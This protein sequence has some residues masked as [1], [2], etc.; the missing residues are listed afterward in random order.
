MGKMANLGKGFEEEVKVANKQYFNKRVAIIQQI[1]TPWKVIR[2]GKKIVHAFPEGK[3]TLDFRGTVKGGL[4]ISFDCKE[5]KVEKGLPLSNIAEHQISYMR[6]AIEFGE[7]SFVLCNITS[8]N[9]RYFVDGKTVIKKW[10]EW[11]ENKGKR[12]YNFIPVLDMIEIK[13]RNGIVLDY[14]APIRG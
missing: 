4:S 9:K 1:P 10:D 8:I 12:G 5:T 2:K 13:S 6:N 3:S 7:V 11:K 14:L